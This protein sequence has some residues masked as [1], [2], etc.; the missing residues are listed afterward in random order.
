[1]FLLVAEKALLAHQGNENIIV[2]EKKKPIGNSFM[3]EVR[4]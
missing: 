2:K 3:M 4:V 1:M